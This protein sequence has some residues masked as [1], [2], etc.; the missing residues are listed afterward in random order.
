MLLKWDRYTLTLTLVD[1]DVQTHLNPEA[2]RM[3]QAQR[4]HYSDA[5]ALNKTQRQPRYIP[6]AAMPGLTADGDGH[7]LDRTMK[8]KHGAGADEAAWAQ[9]TREIGFN[10]TGLTWSRNW[11]IPGGESTVNTSL[12]ALERS[13]DLSDDTAEFEIHVEDGE[14]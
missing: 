14:Y 9:A 7:R 2:D 11:D 3:E 8:V 5:A 13:A 1:C 6:R 12:S 10:D 4:R